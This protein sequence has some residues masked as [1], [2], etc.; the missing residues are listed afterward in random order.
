[1]QQTLVHES[2]S[3]AHASHNE[4]AEQTVLAALLLDSEKM[5]EVVGVL[6]PD[7]FYNSVCRSIYVTMQQLSLIHI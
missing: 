6:S 4:E 3:T 2:K 1:M 5:I 7:D